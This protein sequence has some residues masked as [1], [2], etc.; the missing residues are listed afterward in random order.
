MKEYITE[1]KQKRKTKHW[2]IVASGDKI[3]RHVIE[4]YIS[5]NRPLNIK[6]IEDIV[7][8][9]H[10]NLDCLIDCIVDEEGYEATIR[11]EVDLL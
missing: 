11:V 7:F 10:E 5:R 8:N 9:E 4:Y 1:L 6:S 3:K 2:T